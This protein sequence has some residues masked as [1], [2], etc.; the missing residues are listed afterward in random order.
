MFIIYAY[1]KITNPEYSLWLM[2][3]D[4]LHNKLFEINMIGFCRPI[5]KHPGYKVK[6]TEYSGSRRD[7]DIE[8]IEEALGM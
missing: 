6:V 7:I 2:F 5:H 1:I 4:L 8:K 3:V